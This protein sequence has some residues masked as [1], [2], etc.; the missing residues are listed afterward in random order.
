MEIRQIVHD[1]IYVNYQA[2]LPRNTKET[3]N[4]KGVKKLSEPDGKT[5]TAILY[6]LDIVY[7]V[8]VTNQFVT[9]GLLF[10]EI[11]NRIP[12]YCLFSIFSKPLFNIHDIKGQFR[13][14]LMGLQLGSLGTN[15]YSSSANQKTDHKPRLVSPIR[16]DNLMF[17][18]QY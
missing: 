11:D 3:S 16:Y 10:K 4:R 15:K 5:Y 1:Y 2:V 8:Y 18:I 14:I 17:I 9:P 6:N 13:Q 12:K 7:E